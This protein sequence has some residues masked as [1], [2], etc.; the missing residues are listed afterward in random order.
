MNSKTFGE[1]CY[2]SESK[3]LNIYDLL[4]TS[5]IFHTATLMH[6]NIFLNSQISYNIIFEAH[7]F[8]ADYTIACLCLDK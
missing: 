7:T 4:K 6:K 1:T 5:G 2:Y 3:E 8:I